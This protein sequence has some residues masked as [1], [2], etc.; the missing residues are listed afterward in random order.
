MEPLGTT[1]RAALLGVAI[2]AFIVILPIL[3][4][5]VS[6]FRFSLAKKTILETGG[7]YVHRENAQAR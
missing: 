6:G 5:Y 4:L 7:I 2:A 3:F 1:K